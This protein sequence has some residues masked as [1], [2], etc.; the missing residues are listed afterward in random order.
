MQS[1]P[2]LNKKTRKS[3][4]HVHTLLKE[5]KNIQGLHASPCAWPQTEHKERYNEEGLQTLTHKN[6]PAKCTP[7]REYKRDGEKMKRG[8]EI[9]SQI[10]CGE[11]GTKKAQEEAEW[12]EVKKEIQCARK[13]GE[14]GDG[15][16]ER[17]EVGK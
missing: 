10:F 16:N 13:T 2:H 1:L 11:F 5:D 7:V 8:E 4:K 14:E 17:R 15:R 12:E 6:E 9:G 3:T